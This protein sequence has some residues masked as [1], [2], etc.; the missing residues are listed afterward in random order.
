ME[1]APGIL[2]WLVQGCIDWQRE[3]LNIPQKVLNKTNQYRSDEDTIGQ[4]FIDCVEITGIKSDFVNASDLYESYQKWCSK[5]GMTWTSN[6]KFGKRAADLPSV[7]RNRLSIG[8]VYEG[9][10]IIL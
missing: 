7:T 4:Y 9:L 3:G 2:A 10:K 5:N 1:E 6:V 8:K